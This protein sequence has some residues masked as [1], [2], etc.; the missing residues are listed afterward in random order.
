MEI[1]AGFLLKAVEISKRVQETSGKKLVDFVAGL[2]G[3]EEIKSVAA[4]VTAYARQ[5]SIPGV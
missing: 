3:D 2:E 5:F 4:E 1:V